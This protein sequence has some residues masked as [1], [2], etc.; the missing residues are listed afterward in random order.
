ML[1]AWPASIFFGWQWILGS[2]GD[3]G[4]ADSRQRPSDSNGQFMGLILLVE[5]DLI[6]WC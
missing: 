4:H 5:S 2:V 3:W 1:A 6:I